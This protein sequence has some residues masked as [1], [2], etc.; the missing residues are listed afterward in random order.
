MAVHKFQQTLAKLI[1][2]IHAGLLKQAQKDIY[3]YAEVDAIDL[4]WDA[5]IV[6]ELPNVGRIHVYYLVEGTGGS[7]KT[8]NLYDIYI[9]INGDDSSTD[10]FEKI[11]Q[12]SYDMRNHYTLSELNTKLLDYRDAESTIPNNELNYIDDIG[13]AK[14]KKIDD[15]FV[16]SIDEEFPSNNRY[17]M[18]N[19]LEATVAEVALLEDDLVPS[20]TFDD[21]LD[22][23]VQMT[24]DAYRDEFALSNYV[25]PEYNATFG[26]VKDANAN[27][28]YII[29][30]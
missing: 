10:R 30:D 3:T 27:N 29:E 22:D 4:S 17:A 6:Q 2:H 7:K 28:E 9:W 1:A 20:S 14:I 21:S 16:I 12:V 24:E 11:G 26:W 13:F 5:E 25:E 23:I 19:P 15:G 8:G 18:N